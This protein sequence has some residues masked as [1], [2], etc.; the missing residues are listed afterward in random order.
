MRLASGFQGLASGFQGLE[1]GY[2]GLPRLQ[3]RIKQRLTF[4]GVISNVLGQRDL[5]Q[6]QREQ[7]Q[8]FEGERMPRYG[9]QTHVEN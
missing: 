1:S 9:R 4:R 2:Q 6:L 8:G 7:L 5:H 3:Q